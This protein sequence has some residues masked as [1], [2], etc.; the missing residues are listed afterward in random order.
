[1]S[2]DPITDELT[3]LKKFEK[4]HISNRILFRKMAIMHGKG[5]F[6]KSKGS[7]CNIPM[8][9]GNLCDVLPKP[10][11]FNGLIVAKLKRDLKC[12]GLLCFKPVRPYIV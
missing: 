7:I 9:A 5:A 4:L 10:A 1:M 2:L 12:R 11:L 8:K 3:D 6:F